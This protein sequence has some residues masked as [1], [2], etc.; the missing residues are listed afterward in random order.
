MSD[1]RDYR[2]TGDCTCSH[3]LTDHYKDGCESCECTATFDHNAPELAT[4]PWC[5]KEQTV[6][7]I[8]KCSGF[9]P[10]GYTDDEARDA[11]SDAPHKLAGLRLGHQ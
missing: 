9:R 5:F 2:F 1:E 4:C 7:E 11:Y 8:R 10:R 3:R 6:D